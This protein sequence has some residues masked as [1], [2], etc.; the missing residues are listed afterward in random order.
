MSLGY[1]WAR[2]DDKRD[3]NFPILKGDVLKVILDEGSELWVE[4]DARRG[5][6]RLKDCA[7]MHWLDK[8]LFRGEEELGKGAWG[9]VLQ[10]H[11]SLGT[12]DCIRAK[13][14]SN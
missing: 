14:N 4:K 8:A 11:P 5:F 7:D 3:P 13:G 6:A 10:G 12:K 2:K 1:A 9:R